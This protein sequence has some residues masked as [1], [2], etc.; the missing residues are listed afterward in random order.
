M[1]EEEKEIYVCPACGEVY[2][3]EDMEMLGEDLNTDKVCDQCI[4]DGYY[5]YYE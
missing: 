4:I 3:E 5:D 2:Y 1:E